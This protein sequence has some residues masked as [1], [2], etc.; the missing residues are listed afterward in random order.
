MC[1]SVNACM[2]SAV[3]GWQSVR[4][5]AEVV[6]EFQF[7]SLVQR[8]TIKSLFFENLCSQ[9]HVTHTVCYCPPVSS[10]LP[11]STSSFFIL[12]NYSKLMFQ[13]L[14]RTSKSSSQSAP[15]AR[16]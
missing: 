2:R 4:R 6:T 7:E 5:V 1:V 3:G 8:L 11:W 14:K 15:V 12:L 9:L 16:S 13:S 10:N